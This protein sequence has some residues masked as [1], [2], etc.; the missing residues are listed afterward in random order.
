MQTT[1]Y[2]KC[3]RVGLE[4]Y[5]RTIICC[6]RNYFLFCVTRILTC[7]LLENMER[8]HVDTDADIHLC[9]FSYYTSFLQSKTLKLRCQ[10]FGRYKHRH[11]LLELIQESG[12]QLSFFF[13]TKSFLKEKNL[14]NF[15]VCFLFSIWH[16]VYLKFWI[17]YHNARWMKKLNT[18]T[19]PSREDFSNSWQSFRAY[20]VNGYIPY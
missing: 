7:D 4:L 10:Q 17:G 3:R 18:R 9:F 5:V 20:E 19:A 6:C 14:L 13:S 8:D 16:F 11:V 2:S 15:I 12:L 1:S